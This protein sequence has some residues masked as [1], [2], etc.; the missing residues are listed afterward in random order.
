MP[1]SDVNGQPRFRRPRAT[2]TVVTNRDEDLIAELHE[3]RGFRRIEIAAE[4]G[5]SQGDTGPDQLRRLL[6]ESGPGTS[7]LR[8][9]AI[10]ALA[11]RCRDE[12]HDD[13]A[14][15]F[16]SKD[17]GTRD[18]AML[19]LSAYGRD[20]LWDEVAE[21]LVKTLRNRKRR[22]SAPPSEV[23]VQIVYL[24]RHAANEPGRLAR[25]A[26]S[27]R[28]HWAGLEPAS[29]GHDNEQWI[30]DYW[31]EASPDGPSVNTL[32]PPDVSA[33]KRYVTTDPL[34]EPL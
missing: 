1:R 26:A 13:Y 33:M 27:L 24:V 25:L 2:I 30:K 15:A 22:G 8:C 34:F 19:A 28:Q 7:D 5:D 14:V 18:Y 32:E 20:G 21:R 23:V 11:K 10:L 9:T 3:A 4:L 17:A 12:A 29:G 6:R 16:H 31:P